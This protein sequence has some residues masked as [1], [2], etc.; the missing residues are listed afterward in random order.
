MTNQQPIKVTETH[1]DR[2]PLPGK[3]R[4][5]TRLSAAEI[6]RREQ[7]ARPRIAQT[8]SVPEEVGSTT[9]LTGP[10]SGPRTLTCSPGRTVDLPG[11]TVET[12]P[13]EPERVVFS[14]VPAREPAAATVVR[15]LTVWENNDDPAVIAEWV[16]AT[17]I[18]HPATPKAPEVTEDASSQRPAATPPTERDT[19]RAALNQL[20]VQHNSHLVP[21]VR[22]A[23]V[24]LVLE[25]RHVSTQADEYMTRLGI[26]FAI[27]CMSKTPDARFDPFRDI[28]EDRIATY[29]RY[30]G[31]SVSEASKSS[32][33][34]GLRRLAAG[35]QQ[36]RTGKRRVAVEPHER[37]AEDGFWV[38]ADGFH[39]T[40]IEHREAK[41]ML[42]ATF[43]AGALTEEV[44]YLAPEDVL[45]E[46]GRVA[47]RL[48]RDKMVARDVPITNLRYAD[49]LMDR[50]AQLAG[51]RFLFQPTRGER[52]NAFNVATTRVRRANA[53][54]ERFN[55]TA[56]RN[57]WFQHLLVNGVPFHIACAAAGVA[58]GTHLP[59]DLLAYAPPVKA[60]DIEQAVR[61][62]DGG[63]TA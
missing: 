50:A 20:T 19:R 43:G 24:G 31:S 42:A 59:T 56:A 8:P 55:A 7:R 48:V 53:I 38:A 58:P 21:E 6:A 39:H 46:G 27:W 62:L 61:A 54:F 16:A 5:L 2:T 30:L 52:R 44:N 17:A 32:Y 18:A 11:S 14:Q 29:M 9:G 40:G 35:P 25:H 49:W 45:V 1:D 10:T 41:T 37:R 47:L 23:I 13:P 63:G 33:T 34:A 22:D 15:Q 57:A 36:P 51:E 28:T 3:K 60:I 4:R 12:A 26:R